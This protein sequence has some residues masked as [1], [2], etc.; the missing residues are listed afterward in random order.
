MTHL[1]NEQIEDAFTQIR[2]EFEQRNNEYG[3][4]MLDSYEDQWANTGSL[5]D[6]QHAWLKDQ[7]GGAW[8]TAGS[9][10]RPN[11]VVM[12]DPAASDEAEL[13]DAMIEQRLVAKGKI[14][15]NA[16]QVARIKKA[17][18]D[19]DDVLRDVGA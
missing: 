17:I 14:L 15:V 16:D 2:V 7:L 9:K 8:R 10:R 4:G 11:A 18:G 5:S 13:F 19:I 12:A 3:L 1:T 6:G